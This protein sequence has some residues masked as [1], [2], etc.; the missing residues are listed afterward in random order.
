MDL[1]KKLSIPGHE[2]Y[3]S[4]EQ[5]LKSKIGKIF[6]NEEIPEEYFVKIYEID[7][8]FSENYKKMRQV[9]KNGQ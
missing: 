2:T 3:E 9:D 1:E 4:I 7:L 8:H 5:R 6:V